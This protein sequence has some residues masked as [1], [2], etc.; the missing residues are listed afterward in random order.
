MVC[1]CVCL[2]AWSVLDS[3]TQLCLCA[4]YAHTHAA[5]GIE[6]VWH[7]LGLRVC[8]ALGGSVALHLCHFMFS[9]SAR[10]TEKPQVDWHK[11]AALWS[12]CQHF[13]CISELAANL[14]SFVHFEQKKTL[15]CKKRETDYKQWNFLLVV[16]FSYDPVPFLLIS[17][18]NCFLNQITTKYKHT[19]NSPQ[20]IYNPIKYIHIEII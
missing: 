9:H 18:L 4:T 8:C 7:F 12:N 17:K 19:N 13:L 6:N 11:V 1:V 15:K 10:V 20:I 5:E 3:G 16:C 14:N 2:C